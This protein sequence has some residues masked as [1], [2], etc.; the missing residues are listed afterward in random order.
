MS[1]TMARD[2]GPVGIRAELLQQSTLV[3]FME[4]INDL[5]GEP[6]EAIDGMDRHM[7]A[8][9]QGTDAQ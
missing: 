5:V 3:V 4:G 2:L 8:L 1:L 7:E 6:D 9:M